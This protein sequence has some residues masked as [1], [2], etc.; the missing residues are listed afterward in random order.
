M[1]YAALILTSYYT[2]ISISSRNGCAVLFSR[3]C[4]CCCSKSGS[5]VEVASD[6]EKGQMLNDRH[7]NDMDGHAGGHMD[8]DQAN[9]PLQSKQEDEM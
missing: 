6:D 1:L 3:L 9:V 7:G 2:V 5:D 4:S 8:M